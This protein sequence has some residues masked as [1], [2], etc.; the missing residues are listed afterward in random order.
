MREA[1]TASERALW[2]LLRAHQLGVWFRRQ[3]AVQGCIVDFAA[4][5]AK[6]VVEVDGAYHRVA[7]RQRADVRRDRRLSKAG[8]RVLRLSAE[9]VLNQ[10]ETAR[11]LVLEALA[12]H[13]R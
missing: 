12:K 8:W 1:G 13:H 6:L 5:A 11:Q 10:P 2:S 3:V 7:A 4:V 9:L